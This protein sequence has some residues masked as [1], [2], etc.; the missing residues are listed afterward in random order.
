MSKALPSR[1]TFKPRSALPRSAATSRTA[2]FVEMHVVDVE[3]AA[4]RIHVLLH[5]ETEACADV[6]KVGLGQV[7]R[8]FRP[9]VGQG[10][11]AAGEIVRVRII[12]RGSA[13]LEFDDLAA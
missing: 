11:V 1:N 6:R 4:V 8:V 10:D 2:S 7:E 9:A 13:D 12:R 3:R 5:D